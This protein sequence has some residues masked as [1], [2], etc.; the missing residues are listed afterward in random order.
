LEWFETFPVFLRQNKE[1]SVFKTAG[2]FS[3][4]ETRESIHLLFDPSKL[5]AWRLYF[6][7]L[8][9]VSFD[10]FS[11]GFF[12]DVFLGQLL[13]CLRLILVE[14]R[15]TRSNQPREETKPPRTTEAMAS[16][17]SRFANG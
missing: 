7:W 14:A 17:F 6:Y 15:L 3:L 4:L 12:Y 9:S 13:M 10:V 16:P 5:G 8:S 1:K 2:I 11:G